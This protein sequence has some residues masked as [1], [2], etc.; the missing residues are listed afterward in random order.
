MKHIKNGVIGERQRMTSLTVKRCSM[1]PMFELKPL[2]GVLL[3][4]IAKEKMPH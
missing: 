4:K 2:N 1:N 3:V